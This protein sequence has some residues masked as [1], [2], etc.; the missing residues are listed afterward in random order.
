MP[1]F[2][3]SIAALL[4]RAHQLIAYRE[5]LLKEPH[6]QSMLSLRSCVQDPMAAFRR[7]VLEPLTNL[8]KGNVLLCQ[9]FVFEVV[10]THFCTFAVLIFA[11]CFTRLLS[12]IVF[13]FTERKIP[14]ED[15]II[16][17][18]GLNEAE[19]HKPDYG[20]T[21][22]SFITKIIAKFPPWLKLVVTVRVNL[23]VRKSS[24]PQEI[25]CFT[26]FL[27]HV[28][29]RNMAAQVFIILKLERFALLLLVTLCS[30]KS[31]FVRR[32]CSSRN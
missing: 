26:G 32:I 29:L 10:A 24:L 27:A 18:D 31:L 9:I 1:E 23:L 22:A 8:R 20:D 2:V 30:P 14:E 17:I 19:F 11:S 21:I 25:L 13:M 12:V 28:C 7:G 5:L 4:C 16:L 3:H 15:H 6:L